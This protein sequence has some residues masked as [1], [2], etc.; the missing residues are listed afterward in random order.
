MPLKELYVLALTKVSGE[1]YKGLGRADNQTVLQ[2]FKI[3]GDPIVS[4]L[5]VYLSV[6]YFLLFGWLSAYPVIF[7]EGHGLNL[8]ENSLCFIPTHVGIVIA[9]GVGLLFGRRYER[10]TV[11]SGQWPAPEQRLWPCM[12]QTAR[13]AYCE[14]SP[15]IA[16]Q[17]FLEV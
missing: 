9:G 2:P 5:M 11:E 8:G 3:M 13:A 1:C 12:L 6:I 4:I 10:Q 7:M 15:L 16:L 17:C 14:V